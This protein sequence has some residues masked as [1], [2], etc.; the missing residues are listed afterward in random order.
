MYWAVDLLASSYGWAK[1]DILETVYIDELFVFVRLIKRRQISEYKIQLAIATNPNTK[2]PKKLW[3]AFDEMERQ[4]EGK[5][6]L[7][8]EFDE[9]GFAAFKETLQRNSTRFIVK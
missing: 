2:H 6:Y 7:N 9:A 4:N 5:D 1:N 3:D 8:A